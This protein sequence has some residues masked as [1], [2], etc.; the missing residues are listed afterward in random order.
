MIYAAYVRNLADTHWILI[1]FGVDRPEAEMKL[2]KR[3]IHMKKGLKT[4]TGIRRYKN[5]GEAPEKTAKLR[6]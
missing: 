6:G 2:E 3:I 1:G 4:K 5:M